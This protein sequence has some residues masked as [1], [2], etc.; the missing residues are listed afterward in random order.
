MPNSVLTIPTN[1]NFKKVLSNNFDIFIVFTKCIRNYILWTMLRFIKYFG[2]II[3]NVTNFSIGTFFAVQ[4]IL[5]SLPLKALP[6]L[7]R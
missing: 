5:L 7:R 3:A 4:V 2:G 1:I 6:P